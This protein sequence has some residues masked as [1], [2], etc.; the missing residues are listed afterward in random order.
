MLTWMVKTEVV[1]IEKLGIKYRIDPVGV[2]FFAELARHPTPRH[3]SNSVE[4]VSQ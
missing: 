2:R 1:A 4:F 3:L